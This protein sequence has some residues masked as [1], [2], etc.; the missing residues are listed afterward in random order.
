MRPFE[1]STLALKAGKT[2]KVIGANAIW[3][4]N[5]S[6]SSSQAKKYWLAYG[7]DVDATILDAFSIKLTTVTSV[8]LAAIT[9]LTF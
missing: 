1:D 3:L 8:T 7:D 6:S 2:I 4:S 9:A 5:S